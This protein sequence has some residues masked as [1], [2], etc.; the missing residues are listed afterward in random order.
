MKKTKLRNIVK[1]VLAEQIGPPI[2]CEPN[3]C[4]CVPL[5]VPPAP[6]QIV[7]A[8]PAPCFN[9]LDNCCTKW[10]C[11]PA[12]TGQ[13]YAVPG[14]S[15]LPNLFPS[16]LDCQ[17]AYPN[18]CIQTPDYYDCTQD[19]LW[20]CAIVSYTTPHTTQVSCDN[21]YPGGCEPL[22]EYDCNQTTGYVCAQTPGGQYPTLGACLAQWPDGCEINAYECNLETCTCYSDPNGQ[23]TGPNAQLDCQAALADPLSECCCINCT[24]PYKCIDE[25]DGDTGVVTK[26]CVID[27]G[28]NFS[29]MSDCQDCIANPNCPQCHEISDDGY[30]CDTNDMTGMISCIPDLSMTPEYTSLGACQNDIAQPDFI[31]DPSG[32]GWEC[33]E[34]QGCLDTG[35][36]PHPDQATCEANSDDHYNI[37]NRCSCYCPGQPK[38]CDTKPLIS[39]VPV[40][41][42]EYEGIHGQPFPVG[43]VGLDLNIAKDKDGPLLSQSFRER[44]S[45][46]GPSYRAPGG[47]VKHDCA[48][49]EYISTKKLPTKYSSII[50][51]ASAGGL[52]DVDAENPWHMAHSTAPLSGGTA[53]GGY[54]FPAWL[55]GPDGQL[56][57]PDDTPMIHTTTGL[58]I[59][60]YHGKQSTTAHPRWQ[61]RMEAKIAY[62]RCLRDACCGNTEWPGD[63]D[64]FTPFM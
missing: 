49:W 36:G 10:T 5:F 23:F 56:G 19:T 32:G 9:D 51:P 4:M 11:D 6:G 54:P 28:G 35:N 59:N 33:I 61:R 34:G 58:P 55:P 26:V 15:T 13:C 14:N 60:P 57:T 42:G 41:N 30:K 29:T 46:C 12:G 3:S 48:F 18:G 22:R 1:G 50:H 52:A 40:I 24:G 43:F 16:E 53:L 17:N 2:Q 37:G 63:G 47:N 25:V 27:A 20:A 38:G 7:Y 64:I 62:I 45:P 44:M 21:A 31:C 39:N 8:G